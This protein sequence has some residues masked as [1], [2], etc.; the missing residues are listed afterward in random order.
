MIELTSVDPTL[1]NIIEDNEGDDLEAHWNEV[2]DEGIETPHTKKTYE[3]QV[4]VQC[5]RRE[6][7]NPLPFYSPLHQDTRKKTS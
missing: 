1:E 5:V 2:N 4:E 3:S 7:I 6:N